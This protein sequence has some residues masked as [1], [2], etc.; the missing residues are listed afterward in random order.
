VAEP[1]Q[2]EFE[3]AQPELGDLIE[4]YGRLRSDD[5]YA[6]TV[7]TSYLTG[8]VAVHAAIF[9]VY[10]Q[11]SF[12]A[13]PD[14][15]KGLI[16]LVSFG[17]A[18]MFIHRSVD[19]VLRSYM[20]RSLEREIARRTNWS[21]ADVADETRTVPFPSWATVSHVVGKPS[22]R[23][24]PLRILASGGIFV[25]YGL[26]FATAAFAVITMDDGRGSKIVFGLVYSVMYVIV[27]RVGMLNGF[28][29]KRSWDAA[30]AEATDRLAGAPRSATKLSKF[31]WYCLLPRP[32]E[33]VTKGALMAICGVIGGWLVA[34]AHHE[35]A[36]LNPA[37][38][39]RLLAF[40]LMLYQARYMANDLVGAQ[41]DVDHPWAEL[42]NRLPL[43]GDACRDRTR[44]LIV[45]AVVAGRILT[46]AV[47][48]AVSPHAVRLALLV[49]TVVVVVPA[50]VYD[51]A[52][53]STQHPAAMR[54]LAATPQTVTI[55]VVLVT[56][57]FGY[58]VRGTLAVVLTSGVRTDGI[59]W[60]ALFLY[61]AGSA[62]VW[63]TWAIGS[64]NFIPRT[65][66]DTQ[67]DLVLLPVLP[68]SEVDERIQGDPHV[69]FLGN[70]AGFVA[71]QPTF[72]DFEDSRLLGGLDRPVLRLCTRWSTPWAFMALVSMAFACEYGS[73][74]ARGAGSTMRGGLVGCFV[75]LGASALFSST[76]SA[77]SRTLAS[78]LVA[79]AVIPLLVAGESAGRI[80]VRLYP[81][82]LV[83]VVVPTYFALSP[84]VANTTWT[85][86]RREIG[87]S[88]GSWRVA[89]ERA[90]GELVD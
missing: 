76:P 59:V 53:A 37:T 61:S 25:F 77:E 44:V 62:G 50:S 71:W 52:R 39:G 88:I 65:D 6:G 17:L 78:A 26:L 47:W 20:L 90:R 69:L 29:G 9:A 75:L 2:T 74:L 46:W 11:A 73:V 85:A 13:L 49:A 19:E 51:V 1:R 14:N 83:A 42:R 43:T 54:R 31:A 41:L 79:S 10:V 82:L 63:A 30:L 38:V 16:P 58:A 35:A 86:M 23:N 87:R 57:G 64:F 40:E 48:I 89:A 3:P 36:A 80:A 12:Q 4:E 24:T 21:I 33:L 18:G 15:F 66:G 22:S 72:G 70:V 55:G 5:R 67:P 56:V 34:R 68:A 7:I 28:R 45:Q 81:P 32:T 84:K 60:L 8:L 27:V